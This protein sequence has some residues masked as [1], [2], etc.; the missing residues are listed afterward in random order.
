MVVHVDCMVQQQQTQPT[1]M[2][3]QLKANTCILLLSV[4]TALRRDSCFLESSYRKM[5]I[6]MHVPKCLEARQV[7]EQVSAANMLLVDIC[8]YHKDSPTES[9]AALIQMTH[10]LAR[11][12]KGD[13]V[14]L[15]HPLR[16]QSYDGKI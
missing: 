14:A 1:R 4:S 16:C 9:P 15:Q 12:T 11:K 5:W 3:P 8:S 13:R 6:S 7:R 2:M 10:K